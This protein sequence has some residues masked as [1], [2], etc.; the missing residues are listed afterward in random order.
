MIE[1]QAWTIRLGRE[2]QNLGT[3]S[4]D[5]DYARLEH[6]LGSAISQIKFIRKCYNKE[7]SINGPDNR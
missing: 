5:S 3:D 4:T 2:L 7:V 6:E 1:Q